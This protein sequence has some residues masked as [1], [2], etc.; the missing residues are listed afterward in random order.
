MTQAG[1]LVAVLDA[2]VLYPAALRHLLL[3]VAME[4]TFQPRWT[5]AIQDERIRA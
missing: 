2:S 3:S 1:P 4:G 5:D